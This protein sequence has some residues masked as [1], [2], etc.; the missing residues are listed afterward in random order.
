MEAA[1]RVWPGMA[2][3][4]RRGAELW[5]PRDPAGCH[6]QLQDDLGPCPGEETAPVPVLPA[7]E[8]ASFRA[9]FS[10]ARLLQH[11]SFKVRPCCSKWKGHDLRVTEECCVVW[12]SHSFHI[13]S[14][15][16][17][18]STMWLPMHDFSICVWLKSVPL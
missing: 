17:S 6:W 12:T 3:T 13:P 2:S 8:G 15:G 11:F 18:G 10:T 7:E 1:G 5:F 14:L 16:W 9:G 4:V